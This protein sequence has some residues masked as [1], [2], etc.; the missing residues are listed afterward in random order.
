L[1]HKG[2]V[3]GS[4]LL[5]VLMMMAALAPSLT[6]YDPI[7]Q[8]Q[9]ASLRA[10][11]AAHP[12]GT[13]VFGRDI[14]SRVIWGGRQSLR[15]G[16]LAVA[17]GGVTGTLLGLLAGYYRGWTS[18]LILR[19]TDVLLALPG[20]LLA[21]TIVAATGPSLENLIVAVGISSIPAYV[22]I[23]NGTVLDVTTR[24]FIEASRASGAADLRIIG[25]H[26]VPNILAPVIVL[27]T[28]G[29]GNALLIAATLSFLG[30]GAQPPTPEWGAMLSQG[31]EFIFGYWW[32]ATFP[33][34]AI[35]LAVIGTN[36]LGE[37]MRDLLDPR[38]RV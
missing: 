16:L 32:I 31:R 17:V 33:G 1:R 13:D 37:G 9:Q 12:L 24:T 11:G 10:P 22:R 2:A 19:L 26:V 14:L 27:S 21:L 7:A 36:L 15:V 38:L 3:T 8:D 35:L 30:M 4:V 25:R 23:V 6:P 29:L 28:L 18:T 20:I 34:V 5:L